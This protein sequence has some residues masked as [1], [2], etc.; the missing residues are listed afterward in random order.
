MGIMNEQDQ[1]QAEYQEALTRTLKSP[2][3]EEWLKARQVEEG[4]GLA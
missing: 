1:L 2:T 4:I 3:F